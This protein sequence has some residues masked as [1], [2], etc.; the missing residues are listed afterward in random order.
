MKPDVIAVLLFTVVFLVC[1]FSFGLFLNQIAD[2]GVTDAIYNYQPLIAGLLAVL[3]AVIGGW[4]VMTSAKYPE[5]ARKR[6]F[7]QEQMDYCVRIQILCKEINSSDQTAAQQSKVLKEIKSLR[8]KLKESSI[9]SYKE[10]AG[11]LAKKLL[12]AIFK[13][14]T[15]ADKLSDNA[16]DIADIAQ[17]L[18]SELKIIRDSHTA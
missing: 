4:F 8:H 18:Y 5:K 3:A 7:I 1:S 9:F 12:S 11:R 16:P 17:K 15:D 10:S 6:A 14:Q 13:I 2:T